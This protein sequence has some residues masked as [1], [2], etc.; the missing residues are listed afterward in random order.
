MGQYEAMRARNNKFYDGSPGIIE[1]YY[2]NAMQPSAEWVH[3][4]FIMIS[5]FYRGVG[6]VVILFDCLM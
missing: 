5:N 1:G 4:A 3:F 2:D 6:L